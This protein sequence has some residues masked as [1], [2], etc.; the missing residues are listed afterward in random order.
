MVFIRMALQKA[1]KLG[2][3]QTTDLEHLIMRADEHGVLQKKAT[4]ATGTITVTGTKLKSGMVAKIGSGSFI[5][6]VPG[7][8]YV[9]RWAS[10]PG[11][12]RGADICAAYHTPLCHF[13][14]GEHAR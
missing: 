2:F 13:A 10:L 6:P 4:K 11:G 1:L 7:Y 5:W 9:S 8:K 14:S 3:A 12:H